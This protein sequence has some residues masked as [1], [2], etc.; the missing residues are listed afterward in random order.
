MYLRDAPN[1]DGEE[2]GGSV[3]SCLDLPHQEAQVAQKMNAVEAGEHRSASCSSSQSTVDDIAVR[4]NMPTSH[5]VLLLDEPTAACDPLA[6]AAVE[7]LLI[8]TGVACVVV[9]HDERQAAR[10]ATTRVLLTE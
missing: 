4:A 8:K 3:G 6:C 2:E 10:L 1:A 7:R 5:A 9:T